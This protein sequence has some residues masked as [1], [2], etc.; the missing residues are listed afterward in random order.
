MPGYAFIVFAHVAFGALA[1]VAFW[2]AA[3]MKKGSP[4]HRAIGKVFLL[5]MLGIVISGLPLVLERLYFRHQPVAALFLAYLLTITAQACWMAWR[6]VTDKRDWRGLTRRIGWTLNQWLPGLV[7]ALTLAV[8][9][10]TRDP[11]LIG[12]SIIGLVTAL[13]MWRFARKGPDRPNWHI[14][15][16]YQAMLGAGVATHVAFLSIGMRPAWKWLSAHAAVPDM[17]VYLFPWFAPLAVALVAAKWLD[18]KY[19]GPARASRTAAGAA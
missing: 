14:V 11:L 5:A 12:F 15:M 1:L 3:W 18:R 13:R 19:I 6:A 16:H 8:G 10:A 2:S 17:L 4:R 7:A 9:I